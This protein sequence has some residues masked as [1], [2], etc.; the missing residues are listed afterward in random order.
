MIPANFSNPFVTLASGS[1]IASRIPAALSRPPTCVRSG[2][3]A[4]PSVPILWQPMH[5]AAWLMAIG[6]VLPPARPP[7]PPD[8][9]DPPPAEGVE[10]V[11]DVEAGTSDALTVT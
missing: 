3:M 9:P 2:P 1:R 5:P 6:S 10:D 4:A 11:E 8:P 7:P